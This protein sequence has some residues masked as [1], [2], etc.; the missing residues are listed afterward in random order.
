MKIITVFA[1][2]GIIL[3]MVFHGC[4]PAKPESGDIV[5]MVKVASPIRQSNYTQREFSGTIREARE[6]NLAFRVAG[7]MEKIFVKEGDFVRQGELIACVDQ[8]DYQVQAEAL[9]AQYAQVKAE[10]DRLTELNNRK[11]VADNDYEKAIAGEKMLRLQLNHALNQLN[12]T[13][14]TAPFNGYIHSVRYTAGEMVNAGMTIATMMDMQSYQVEVDLPLSVYIRRNDF[15]GFTCIQPLIPDKTYPLQLSGYRKK[16]DNNQLFRAL[17]R[18]DPTA[19]S[20]LTPGMNV[21]VYIEI[22]NQ[23]EELFSIPLSGITYENG[24]TYVWRY[25]PEDS[26]V[27][28]KAVKTASLPVKGMINVV[29]DLTEED[30]IV[31]AGVGLLREG[32]KVEPIRLASETNAGGLM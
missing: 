15:T 4:A 1:N 2:A 29:S 27:T 22:R 3:L 6:I 18:L 11:S 26:T 28:R 32:Q 25:N 5:R 14:L 8:R 7:P 24:R 17:F 20:R 19:D 9:K 13:R 23:A 16:A 12:D 21:T 31:V 30:E 10:F